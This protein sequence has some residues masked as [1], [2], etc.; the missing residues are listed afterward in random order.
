MMVLVY[1]SMLLAIAG[2]VGVIAYSGKIP[3]SI[4]AMVYSFPELSVEKR[5]APLLWSVWLITVGGLLVP[6]MM[7]MLGDELCVFGFLTFGFL[8]G[9]AVTPL[10]NKAT[11]DWHDFLGVSAGLMSQCVVSILSPMW[12]ICWAIYALCLPFKATRGNLV[13]ISEVVCAVS[14]YGSLLFNDGFLMQ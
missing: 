4:S 7:E 8:V 6:P 14:L 10:V 3:K 5:G 2:V 9:A 11:S 13:L 12:L 1:I